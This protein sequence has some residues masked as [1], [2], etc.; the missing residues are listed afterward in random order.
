ME[1]FRIIYVKERIY[2]KYGEKRLNY[3]YYY[4]SLF[5]FIKIYLHEHCIWCLPKDGKAGYL[6]ELWYTNQYDPSAKFAYWQFVPKIIVKK[7][8]DNVKRFFRTFGRNKGSD[9][10][11]DLPF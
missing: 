11:D 6:T 4:Y 7:H 9:P 5:M 10:L 2:Y 8:W 3:D 1:I